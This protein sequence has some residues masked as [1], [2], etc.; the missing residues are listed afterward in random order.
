MLTNNALHQTALFGASA[1]HQ[2]R[3]GGV[4]ATHHFKQGER[5]GN[6]VLT[7]QSVPNFTLCT[8]ANG[9]NGGWIELWKRHLH[10]PAPSNLLGSA[11]TRSTT[12]NNPIALV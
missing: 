2:Q 5:G 1:L 3:R 6:A 4:T 10:P 7:L 8:F 9:D 11:N 12:V